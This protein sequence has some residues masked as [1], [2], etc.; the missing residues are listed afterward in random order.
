MWRVGAQRH[1]TVILAGG[2]TGGLEPPTAS[3]D[4]VTH[5]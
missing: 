3:L 2:F 4:H 5:P 1:S